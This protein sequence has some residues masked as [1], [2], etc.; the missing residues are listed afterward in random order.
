MPSEWC[1]TDKPVTEFCSLISSFAPSFVIWDCW[2]QSES[3][4]FSFHQMQ[5]SCIQ[6]TLTKEPFCTPTRCKASCEALQREPGWTRFQPCLWGGTRARTHTYNIHIHAYTPRTHTHTPQ[7]YTPLTHMHTYVPHV[8]HKPHD[9]NPHTNTTRMYTHIL[10]NIPQIHTPH[11]NMPHACIN[12]TVHTT[13]TCMHL[14]VHARSRGYTYTC[15]C[16]PHAYTQ[17]HTCSHAHMHTHA[18][19]LMCHPWRAGVVLLM[20]GKTK[21]PPQV[22]D[23]GA[24]LL[25]WRGSQLESLGKQIPRTHGFYT[26]SQ[27]SFHILSCTG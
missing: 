7:T 22:R 21:R 6:L 16:T 2:I 13:E 14:H 20:A 5:Y 25:G 8:P 11:K 9:T 4:R 10:I 3:N 15:I 17:I 1:L 23:L 26:L 19:R 27:W 18:V 24:P 12:T